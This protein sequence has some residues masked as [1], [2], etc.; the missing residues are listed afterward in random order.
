MTGIEQ[1]HVALD[2]ALQGDEPPAFRERLHQLI[3]S[4]YDVGYTVG[5]KGNT[6]GQSKPE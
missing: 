3:D 2:E 6:I 4:A 1:V 5:I